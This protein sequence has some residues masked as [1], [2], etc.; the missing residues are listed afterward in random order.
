MNTT[1]AGAE[2]SIL[3]YNAM[4]DRNDFEKHVLMSKQMT[5]GNIHAWLCSSKMEGSC[6]SP[7]SSSG[8]QSAVRINRRGSCASFS[9]IHLQAYVR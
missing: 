8:K 6:T 5:G 9:D 1:A 2:T 4:P 7:D 3:E